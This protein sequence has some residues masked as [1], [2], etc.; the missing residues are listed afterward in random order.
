VSASGAATTWCAIVLSGWQW[1]GGEVEC[2]QVVDA[3]R[4]RPCESGEN[5]LRL[6]NS[7]LVPRSPRS[8]AFHQHWDESTW[9]GKRG[10]PSEMRWCWSVRGRRP[11]VGLLWLVP[12]HHTNEICHV[13]CSH[14]NAEEK[15]MMTLYIHKNSD[16]PSHTTCHLVN[17]HHPP[18][19]RTMGIARITI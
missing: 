19:A 16:A 17:F 2:I 9:R 8:T 7:A 4:V 12:S 1:G 13:R 11:D 10:S 14:G 5:A 15:D 3:S 6:P 18:I